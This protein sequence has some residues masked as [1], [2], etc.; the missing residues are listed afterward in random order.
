LGD[1]RALAA[2]ERHVNDPSL[3]IRQRVEAALQRLQGGSVGEPNVLVELGPLKSGKTNVSPAVVR[4][5]HRASRDGLGALSG[6]R[7]LDAK[8]AAAGDLRVPLVKVTGSLK[9]L[10][11]SKADGKLVCAARVEY[12][13]QRMPGQVIAAVVSGSAK[14]TVGMDVLND[15]EALEKLRRQA[16]EAAVASALRRAPEALLK[17]ATR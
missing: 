13:L 3:T 5:L 10:E 1:D 16:V 14:T 2:L 4:A 12:V 8:G 9:A 17:V 11:T 6:V 7:M 15:R